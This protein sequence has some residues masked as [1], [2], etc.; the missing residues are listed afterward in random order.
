MIVST[1]SVFET[2]I[3]QCESL[4]RICIP[5]KNKNGLP[6]F[7]GSGVT[8]TKRE[9]EDATQTTGGLVFL[10]CVNLRRSRSRRRLSPR[11]FPRSCSLVCTGRGAR[12]AGAQGGPRARQ[13]FLR[14]QEEPEHFTTDF[15][16][17]WS[18]GLG[19]LSE[20]RGAIGSAQYERCSPGRTAAGGRLPSARGNLGLWRTQRRP[21]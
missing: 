6:C 4:D 20:G 17:V 2:G 3:A 14:E 11:S 15:T 1:W 8:K 13:A 12:V 7:P 21:S 9:K 5:Y 16:E 19:S 10:L 18:A